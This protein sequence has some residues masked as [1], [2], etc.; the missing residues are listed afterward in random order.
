ML[1]VTCMLAD[2]PGTGM[3][4]AATV[5]ATARNASSP[6]EWPS[7]GPAAH[8]INQP[9]GGHAKARTD[10]DFLQA[11][12]QHMACRTAIEGLQ[13]GQRQGD[14]Q[15]Q[16]GIAERAQPVV[17]FTTNGSAISELARRAIGPNRRSQIERLFVLWLRNVAPH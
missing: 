11:P 16:P 9:G 10:H 13:Q 3:A 5:V 8:R 1:M 7:H 17:R 15:C 6:G 4:H 2:S 14:E 12:P